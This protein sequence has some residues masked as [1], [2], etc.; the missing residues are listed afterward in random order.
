MWRG[1]AS[2]VLLPWLVWTRSRRFGGV[3]E[4]FIPHFPVSSQLLHL[5]LLCC[6]QLTGSIGHYLQYNASVTSLTT[7]LSQHNNF[8]AVFYVWSTSSLC[9]TS[10]AVPSSAGLVLPSLFCHSYL[11]WVRVHNGGYLWS[12]QAPA[13]VFQL[14]RLNWFSY[15]FIFIFF[16]LRISMECPLVSVF[17][18]IMSPLVKRTIPHN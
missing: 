5:S 11:P 4:Y 12:H 17:C 18:F 8:T 9:A 16:C 6:I 2:K 10:A 14:T 3:Q 15:C 7:Y 1:W 13:P